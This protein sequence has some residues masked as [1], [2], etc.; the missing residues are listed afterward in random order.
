MRT[1]EGCHGYNAYSSNNRPVVLWSSTAG[2][3]NGE[4]ESAQR[5]GGNV[6]AATRKSPILKQKVQRMDNVAETPSSPDGNTS[7][8]ARTVENEF[9]ELVPSTKASKHFS[10]LRQPTW[11]S[12]VTG[13]PVSRCEITDSAQASLVGT[14]ED[15]RSLATNEDVN[16][17]AAEPGDVAA[18]SLNVDAVRNHADELERSAEEEQKAAMAKSIARPSADEPNENLAAAAAASKEEVVNEENAEDEPV[19][20]VV[21]GGDYFGSLANTMAIAKQQSVQIEEYLMDVEVEH[22]AVLEKQKKHHRGEQHTLGDHMGVAGRLAFFDK[23]RASHNLRLALGDHDDDASVHW[24]E[25]EGRTPRSRY[26]RHVVGRSGELPLPV[27]NRTWEDPH[28]INLEGRGIGD[29]VMLSLVAVL[30]E[31]PSLTELNVADNMLTDASLVPLMAALVDQDEHGV[32]SLNISSNDMDEACHDLEKY[33]AEDD[34]SLKKLQMSNS[35]IDDIECAVFMKALGRNHTVT[36][37]NLSHNEIGK[38][39]TRNHVEPSFITGGEAI[40]TMLT[41]N[42]TLHHLDLSWNYIMKGSAEELGNAVSSN[43]TLTSLCL[44]HNTF[45]DLGSQRLAESMRFNRVIKNLDLSYNDVSPRAALV[46]A[47]V[48]KHNEVLNYFVLEGNPLG[49]LGSEALMVGLSQATNGDVD[50]QLSIA[51]CETRADYPNLFDAL[52]PTGTY[53][54]D[55]SLPYDSMVAQTLLRLTNTKV[56][57]EIVGLQHREA[58]QESYKVITLYRGSPPVK[59]TDDWQ[60]LCI[61][62]LEYLFVTV[63]D[64]SSASHAES[65]PVI[66]RQIPLPGGVEDYGSVCR[67]DTVVLCDGISELRGLHAHEAAVVEVAKIFNGKLRLK[68][69]RDRIYNPHIENVRKSSTDGGDGD[70]EGGDSSSSSSSSNKI[71]RQIKVSKY[72]ILG[73]FDA[74][75]VTK[76]TLVDPEIRTRV[77][78]ILKSLK[79]SPSG[80]LLDDIAIDMELRRQIPY[81]G[82]LSEEDEWD[83]FEG[84]AGAEAAP[85]HVL[86]DTRTSEEVR[87]DKKLEAVEQAGLDH[88]R[89]WRGKLVKRVRPG[90]YDLIPKLTQSDLA[91]DDI[92]KAIFHIVFKRVDV[93]KSNQ[94]DSRELY[95]GM[96]A[97]GASVNQQDVE[98][99][100]SVYDIDGGGS[101][102][103]DEFTSCLMHEYLQKEPAPK[104]LVYDNFTHLPWRLPPDGE[105]IVN[106]EAEPTPPKSDEGISQDKGVE[107]LVR[108]ILGAK[109]DME[110]QELMEK[111]IT[112]EGMILSAKHAQFMIDRC[113]RG[114]DI[115]GVV[116]SILPQVPSFSGRNEIFTTN[117]NHYERFRARVKLGNAFGPLLGNG[118]GHYRLDLS[119][120]NDRLAL[121]KLAELNNLEKEVAQ[122]MELDTPSLGGEDESGSGSKFSK[123]Y[124]NALDTSQKGNWSNFRNEQFNNAAI[125]LNHE[126]FKDIPRSGSLEFDYVSTSRPGKGATQ[127]SDAR[128]VQ[129]AARLRLSELDYSR[130]HYRGRHTPVTAIES[131]FFHVR[132]SGSQ[133]Q[134]Q[135]SNDESD[136]ESIVSD[137]ESESSM[138]SEDNDDAHDGF[139]HSNGARIDA[140]NSRGEHRMPPCVHTKDAVHHWQYMAATRKLKYNWFGRRFLLT[141]DVQDPAHIHDNLAYN[142]EETNVANTEQVQD[143]EKHKYEG[144][145]PEEEGKAVEA[146]PSSDSKKHRNKDKKKHH[147]GKK[148]TASSAESEPEAPPAEHNAEE[149]PAQ[150]AA[151]AAVPGVI[152]SS[153]D[154]NNMPYI[155]HDDWHHKHHL[156][157]H[158]PASYKFVYY[159]L[160]ELHSTTTSLYFSATQAAKIVKMFP[161]DDFC[162]VEA[163]LIL[164][165][166]IFNV[167]RFHEIL[168]ELSPMERDEVFHRVGVM[169]C[170]SSYY[171]ERALRDLDLR[172]Y[173]NRQIAKVF[174]KLAID[175]PGENM[176]NVAFRWSPEDPFIPGYSIPLC[177]Q[178]DDG[179]DPEKPGMAG[180][181]QVGNLSIEYRTDYED[182]C[183]P[184]WPLRRALA[185]R[186]MH[187]RAGTS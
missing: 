169:N 66:M 141:H 2:S 182:G 183:R 145:D 96:Q 19:V 151:A 157:D 16:D 49:R 136:G 15:M 89:L 73:W 92:M 116:A 43:F 112:S 154:P 158:P 129:I 132:Y 5:V 184:D 156:S 30:N 139:D 72:E 78:A 10:P 68:L 80:A 31:L 21:H 123:K 67:G 119:N 48:L 127:L 130:K 38:M 167:E 61:G 110:R 20:E 149:G 3:R 181:R 173:D 42:R 155:T 177:W 52:E 12:R 142:T 137:C 91:P 54:L 111:A 102:E 7:P 147:K 24:V 131:D 70:Q 103:I 13:M 146:T 180:I 84:G 64:F 76:P 168:D 162:R 144:E 75:E 170:M 27:L 95:Q 107:E 1:L 77:Q 34:C 41:Q 35:D 120:K 152:G 4:Y 166:R 150:T 32:K 90:R 18:E 172:A 105:L 117:L 65:P 69:K 178:Y 161:A 104:G 128:F 53:Y 82:L 121:R 58:G 9:T 60:R 39:E 85:A 62:L 106:F 40:A 113:A 160:L 51:N 174:V 14:N 185:N 175:E 47:E 140:V 97:L 37:L 93:D 153:A 83:D 125:E 57:N 186:F 126:W 46:M 45:H 122:Q 176:V 17:D 29:A 133:S 26:L 187:G 86:L 163:A 148:H 87:A 134:S 63:Q 165:S 98:R 33:L 100:M 109:N 164:F 28:T 59:L 25:D 81:F 36:F 135:A 159:K 118:T 50:I 88:I 8:A 94:V 56:G 108:N 71:S 115:M 114:L 179:E 99:T 79:M 44:S 101:F 171:P 6:P 22:K 143:D 11:Y 23:C 124:L 55:L 138:L 74:F